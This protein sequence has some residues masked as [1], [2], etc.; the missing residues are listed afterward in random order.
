MQQMA[1]AYC[2]LFPKEG[3]GISGEMLDY[4]FHHKVLYHCLEKLLENCILH[5]ISAEG[6]NHQAILQCS[7]QYEL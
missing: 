1:R 6:K 2:F 5:K 7:F 4:T 3:Q